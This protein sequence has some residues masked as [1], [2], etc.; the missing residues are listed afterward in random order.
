MGMFDYIRCLYPLP[1]NY[2]NDEEFQTKSTPAQFLD[3]YEIRKDGS[4]WYERYDLED[5]SDPTKEGIDKYFGILTRTNIKWIPMKDFTGEIVFYTV[6]QNTWFDFSAYFI[7]GV[8]KSIHLIKDG[9][10]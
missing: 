3:N 9:K 7:N 6:K 8:L 10:K 4:L 1:I 2:L 5:H